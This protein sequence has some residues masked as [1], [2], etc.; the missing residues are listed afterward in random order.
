MKKASQYKYYLIVALSA[1]IIVTF[2]YIL[3][4]VSPFGD[5]SLLTIDFYH[6]YG[7]MLGE[8]YRRIYHHG[9]LIYSFTM[10]LGQPFYR[11]F[12]NYL[13][14]PFNLLILLFKHEDLLTSYSF[15]IGLKSVVTAITMSIFL[16]WKFGEDYKLVPLALMYAFCA[17]FVAYYWNIMWID[18]MYMLP[19]IALGIEKLVKNDKCLLYV[20]SLSLMLFINYFIGY[21]LCLFS[22]LYFIMYLILSMKKFDIEYVK[23]K[24]ITFFISSLTVGVLCAFFLVP[25]FLSLKSISATG[26][27]WPTTQYYDF[28]FKQFLFSHFSGINSTMLKS[29]GICSPNVSC[30][31]V[32][33]ALLLLFW[34]ND[35]IN[36]KVKL[37]YTAF[38]IFLILSFTIA[39]LDYIWHGMHVPND[40]PYRYSFI[41]SFILII[42][43]GYSL[44]NLKKIK[45]KYV[46]G[47]YISLIIGII[48]LKVLNYEGINN[49]MI[50]LNAVII[51]IYFLGYVFSLKN[52]KTKKYIIA[53]LLLATIAEKILVINNNWYIDQ[54]IAT[55]YEKDH[56][57]KEIKNNIKLDDNDK[58]YRM[59]KEESLTFNDP[60]W[61]DYHGI[62]S[63]SSMEYESVAKLL[64]NL[65]ISG[66]QI[67]SYEYKGNT[68]V[69]DL[70][71]NLKYLLGFNNLTEQ[72]SSYAIIDEL[73]ISKNE[74]TLGLMY[75]VNNDLKKWHIYNDVPFHNQNSFIKRATGVNDVLERVNDVESKL[76]YADDDHKIMRYRVL[77]GH[78]NYFFY[79]SNGYGN[80]DFITFGDFLYTIGEDYDYYKNYDEIK[81][82]GMNTY[83]EQYMLKTKSD[84]DYFDFYIGYHGDEVEYLNLFTLNEEKFI[85]AYDYLQDRKVVIT[86]FKEDYIEG[87][88]NAKEDMMIY[89]SIPYDLGWQV[90][91]DDNKVDTYKIGNALLAFPISEGN[92]T[93]MLK[94]KINYIWLWLSINLI[95]LASYIVVIKYGNK[96]YIGFRGKYENK[97]NST[98][99]KRTK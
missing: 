63:F 93:I 6:Q 52:K 10:G 48:L 26:D 78:D 31:V 62:L 17:Y 70:M 73:E 20:I 56:T 71:F 79:P 66:N 58:F 32:S 67:N 21:M 22:V 53:C 91:V 96:L 23:K 25:L 95:I 3:K 61:Y 38:L 81:F 55:F 1:I 68:P 30:G 86:E 84:G 60:S 18:G 11:N 89:T 29:D 12:F 90:Y 51:T 13:S 4:E 77:S 87:K 74:Y 19:I 82:L 57:V 97:Y 5:N 45:S 65:G 35:K 14:S 98:S 83:E 99:I 85:E 44:V 41:Y 16:K 47:V 49:K 94:Y 42:I 80:I 8:L 46:V 34:L 88:I 7:P 36:I 40:L 9:S 54:N 69:F 92:H 59:A 76:V 39:P 27:V 75:G 37:C 2:S 33:L 72:Y 24:T 28:T 43:A 64:Y 15:I 50:I